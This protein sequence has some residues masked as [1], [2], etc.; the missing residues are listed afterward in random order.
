[1]TLINPLKTSFEVFS[2]LHVAGDPLILVNAW[3]TASAVVIEAAGALAVG[4]TSAGAAWSRGYPDGNLLPLTEVL[5]LTKSIS[6]LIGVPLTVDIE[7]GYSNS[8]IEIVEFAASVLESGAV[9]INIED[10]WEGELLT[11]SSQASRIKRLS[12][13]VP[14][15]F[16]NA[17]IDTF[18]IGNDSPS[19]KLKEAIER[20]KEFSD[21][22]AHGIFVPGL[23]DLGA[24]TELVNSI[25]VPVNVM[26]GNGSTSV[27]NL[28]ATGVSRL[29]VGMALAQTVY[30]QTSATAQRIFQDGQFDLLIDPIDYTLMNNFFSE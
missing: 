21:A 9:G 16:I 7:A 29:S 15:F 23:S 8:D 11:A 12:I 28:S 17:R 5:A 20:A 22:G 6:R 26:V 13:E 14:N 19:E 30:Q 3:D 10:S 18:L 4:T 25:K 24:I 27:H 2:A 1:M